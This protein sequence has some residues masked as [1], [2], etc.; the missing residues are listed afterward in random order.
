VI[1]HLPSN[2]KALSSSSCTA[3][4]NPKQQ[5]NTQLLW[6]NEPVFGFFPREMKTNNQEKICRRMFI[7]A[8]FI[9]EINKRK[10]SM[11]KIL[12]QLC[13]THSIEY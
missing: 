1:E 4:N 10:K 13:C 6:L 2:C 3:K 11:N 9:V 7:A 12:N 5:E 8:S